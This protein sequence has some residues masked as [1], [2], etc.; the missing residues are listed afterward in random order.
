MRKDTP[1]SSS[2][3]APSCSLLSEASAITRATTSVDIA[4][5]TRAAGCAPS[6][7]KLRRKQSGRDK[8]VKNPDV[9]IGTSTTDAIS[10]SEHVSQNIQTRLLRSGMTPRF[11][12]FVIRGCLAGVKARPLPDSLLPVFSDWLA[13]AEGFA[14]YTQCSS[15]GGPQ[16]S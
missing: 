3:S 13:E 9:R 8:T 1:G 15:A 7:A 12:N 16:D 4:P 2:G 5:L 6:T 14:L 10:A 11:S